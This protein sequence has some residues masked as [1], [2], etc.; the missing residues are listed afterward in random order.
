[1]NWLMKL[2]TVPL[3]S[4]FYWMDF[5]LCSNVCAISAH[6]FH[7]PAV[8]RYVKSDYCK[9][10]CLCARFLECASLCRSALLDEKR[11]LEAR[12][13]QLEEELEEEQ[14]N[15]ELL[16]DRFRKTTLQVAH[17]HKKNT[18]AFPFH[19]CRLEEII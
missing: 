3:E 1:M 10:S 12:I 16:N 9:V 8:A 11:R 5:S 7:S 17:S 14:S 2:P 18:L 19:S 15:M 6:A 4:K 13:A